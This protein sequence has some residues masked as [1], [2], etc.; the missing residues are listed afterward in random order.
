MLSAKLQG[1]SSRAACRSVSLQFLLAT[2]K[3]NRNNKRLQT[4]EKKNNYGQA[5]KGKKEQ[6]Q[7]TKQNPPPKQKATPII[8]SERN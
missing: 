3:A 8:T 4:P 6:K 5:N 2:A 7:T 1:R